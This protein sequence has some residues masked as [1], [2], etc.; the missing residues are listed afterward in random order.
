MSKIRTISILGCG[1]LGLPLAQFF[2]AKGHRVKGSTTTESKLSKLEEQSI[3]PYF[4]RVG[5]QAIEGN[6][7][8]FLE[9][10]DVLVINFPPKRVPDIRKVY[11]MQT[12]T[13]MEQLPKDL[14]TIFV[15][16]TSVYQNTNSVVVEDMQTEPEKDSGKALLE[17]EQMLHYHLRDNYTVLRLAGLVGYDR[18]PGR[19]LADKKDLKNGNAPVNVIHQDDCIGL[20]NRIIELE[21]WGEIYNGCADKHP[22]RKDYYTRAAEVI[23]LTP[24][25]FNNEPESHF[26]IV[27]NEKSKK[28]LNYQYKYPNP[29][30]ML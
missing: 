15:S 6:F 7:A 21:K 9:G 30:K 16:S 2:I 26:K 22:L 13:I 27:G 1:W 19:F 28:E 11:P 24:P 29:I 8:D 17:A 23:G 4:I 10:T 12:A 18:L 5:E 25:T 20:I 14:K 3:E